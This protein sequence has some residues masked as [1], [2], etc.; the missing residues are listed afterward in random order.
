MDAPIWGSFVYYADYD[1]LAFAWLFQGG[2]HIAA[3]YHGIQALEKY[4]KG[5][6]LSVIDPAGKTHPY[7]ANQRWLQ[8]HNLARLA[9][10]CGKQYPYYATTQVQA[11]LERFSEFDRLARYPWVKQAHGNG[12]TTEDAPVICE[13]LFRLRTDIPLMSDDYPLG[14][15]VRGH[16][17]NHPEYRVNPSW[18]TMHAPS[19]ASVRKMIPQIDKMVRW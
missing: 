14:M 7:P 5:L 9:K 15:F 4:L 8:D 19:L 12:F 17:Q 3:Y 10:R 16:H 1:L 13:L 2:L 18:A 6:A 11:T